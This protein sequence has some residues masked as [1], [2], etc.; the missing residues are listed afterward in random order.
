MIKGGL[1]D[2]GRLREMGS[3]PF[4]TFPKW[5]ADSS[6]CSPWVSA[7]RLGLTHPTWKSRLKTDCSWRVWGCRALW[8]E[9]LDIMEQLS[10]PSRCILSVHRALGKESASPPC[11]WL[12]SRACLRVQGWD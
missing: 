2:T 7:L 10:S 4:I 9:G 5:R 1:V 8:A 12:G 3:C 11:S 6:G